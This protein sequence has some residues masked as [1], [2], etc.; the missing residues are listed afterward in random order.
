MASAMC[1]YRAPSSGNLCGM[2]T[3]SAFR[4]GDIV[5]V[6]AWP[7]IGA[8]ARLLRPARI[9]WRR[10]W[11]AELIDLPNQRVFLRKT[12]LAESV[13]TPLTGETTTI[14]PQEKRRITARQIGPAFLPIALGSWGFAPPIVALAINIPV[15]VLLVVGYWPKPKPD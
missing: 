3:D 12:R 10:G 7:H 14:G 13:I 1:R 11:L 5:T 9:L 6:K 4:V 15:G 2:G 8:R